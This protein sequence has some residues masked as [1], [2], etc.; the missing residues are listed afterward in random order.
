M[1]LIKIGLLVLLGACSGKKNEVKQ[2]SINNEQKLLFLGS[3]TGYPKPN[4]DILSTQSDKKLIFIN[5]VGRH[6]SRYMTKAKYD[7]ASLKFLEE[8]KLNKALTEKGEQLLL[9]TKKLYEVQKTAYGKI[10]PAGAQ[11]QKE[12]ATRIKNK[13]SDLFSVWGESKRIKTASTFKTRT[14]QSRNAF[15]SSILANQDSTFR[16]WI[17]KQKYTK[18]SDS[19]LRFFDLSPSFI[20]FDDNGQWE[21]KVN[22]IAKSEKANKIAEGIVKPLL[23]KEWYEK[24]EKGYLNYATA[25]GKTIITDVISASKSIYK[26][27]QIAS[28][29]KKD[30]NFS[31]F[32]TNEQEEFYE[33]MSDFETFYGEGPGEAKNDIATV[34][35]Y[36]LLNEF[37]NSTQASIDN[38]ESSDI[39]SFRFGHAETIIPFVSI[40]GIE[41]F[42]EKEDNYQF[43]NKKRWKS[44]K[45]S[46]MSANVMWLV[47]MGKDSKAYIEILHNEIPVNIP[48]EKE[49]DGLYQ[50]EK[51][52]EYYQTKLQDY[53]YGTKFN[54]IYT[55]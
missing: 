52:K 19:I 1:K 40:L 36:P 37:L 11:E 31:P 9:E 18:E 42:S 28:G 44:S 22:K 47:Y 17:S 27:H 23:T 41:G 24:L 5:H 49:K 54:S 43:E 21:E 32:F 8:A 20:A 4:K 46:P 26:M 2:A 34:I 13:Y 30:I 16:N 6:G 38:L 45:V 33:F 53:G 39:A 10:T 55:L 29:L 3:K 14:D 12:I 25:Y 51:V 50:W 15:I 35:A 48:I 7:Y